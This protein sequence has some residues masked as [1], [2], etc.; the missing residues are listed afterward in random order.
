MARRKNL[1]F[2]PALPLD[3]AKHEAFAQEVA[4][5]QRLG[6]AYRLAGYRGK[7][8]NTLDAASSALLRRVKVGARIEWLQMQ[9]A[10]ETLLTREW[11][12]GQMRAQ[13]HAASSEGNRNAAIKALELLGRERKTFIDKKELGP[14]GAFSALSDDELNAHIAAAERTIPRSPP[15]KT[16]EG[17]SQG[18]RGKPN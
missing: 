6:T 16:I 18:P 7:N 9:A 10:D 14:P 2:D 13:F 5:G 15:G 1:D 4:K 17:R 12:I 3:Q 11:L 8:R